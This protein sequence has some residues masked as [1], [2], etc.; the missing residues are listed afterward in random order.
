MSTYTVPQEAAEFLAEQ[1][2][3]FLVERHSQPE[4]VVLDGIR[5]GHPG[6]CAEVQT[7]TDLGWRAMVATAHGASR[8]DAVALALQTA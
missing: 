6:L 1:V 2:L 5:A 3:S 7:L 4:S 8:E